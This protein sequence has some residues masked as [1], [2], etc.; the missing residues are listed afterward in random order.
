MLALCAL[1]VGGGGGVLWTHL[2]RSLSWALSHQLG[3]GNAQEQYFK[4]VCLAVRQTGRQFA[5]VHSLFLH[6]QALCWLFVCTI[7]N[8]IPCF[9][10]AIYWDDD[11]SSVCLVCVILNTSNQKCLLARI[12]S[13]NKN[14]CHCSR[15]RLGWPLYPLALLAWPFS[16]AIDWRL[17]VRVVGVSRSSSSSSVTE[18]RKLSPEQ[19]LV[20]SVNSIKLALWQNSAL[21]GIKRFAKG[22]NLKN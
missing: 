3:P 15:R 1:N 9:S 19:P 18:P 22:T 10:R 12:Y 2:S 5:V 8:W 11:H 17:F 13:V 20:L 7:S 16:I 21:T 4:F 14:E 6:V